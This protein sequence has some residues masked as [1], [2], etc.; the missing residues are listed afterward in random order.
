M[1]EVAPTPEEM[2]NLWKAYLAEADSA[3]RHDPYLVQPFPTPLDEALDAVVAGFRALSG[4]DRSLWKAALPFGQ[5]DSQI[6]LTYAVRM[7]TQALREGS[8]SCITNGLLAHLIEGERDDW[9]ENV[10]VLTLLFDAA[11]KLG[12]EPLPLFDGAASLAPGDAAAETLQD[13]RK[14]KPEVLTIESM[15]Y[16]TAMSSQGIRYEPDPAVWRG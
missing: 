15:G 12:V 1:S 11:K 8:A 3:G 2:D 5:S 7:A 6:L 13:F 9:R 16:R 10:I 4:A 14:R